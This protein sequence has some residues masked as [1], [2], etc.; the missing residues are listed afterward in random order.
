MIGRIS[1][2][3]LISSILSYLSV[4]LKR[5]ISVTINFSSDVCTETALI[6]NSNSYIFQHFQTL[7]GGVNLAPGL[8]WCVLKAPYFAPVL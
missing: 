7:T 3:H 5:F 6:T 2:V 1:S 4:N 8:V